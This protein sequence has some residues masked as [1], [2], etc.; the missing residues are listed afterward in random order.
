MEEALEGYRSFPGGNHPATVTR[1]KGQLRA[2]KQRDGLVFWRIAAAIALLLVS[3]TVVWYVNSSADKGLAENAAEPER[4]QS[5]EIASNF[6]KRDTIEL[7]EV[8]VVAED[9]TPSLNSYTDSKERIRSI[10]KEKKEI[11]PSP[12]VEA[13]EARQPPE[14]AKKEKVIQAPENLADQEDILADT[15]KDVEGDPFKIFD[16]MDME[17]EESITIGEE[18]AAVEDSV[19]YP[20]EGR[21]QFLSGRVT[22]RFGDPV[23]G[24]IIFSPSLERRVLTDDLGKI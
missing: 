21:I 5:T 16:E 3:G 6:I 2:K 20:K 10:A 13:K 7:N 12:I 1:L 19:G 17:V 14:P 11:A 8:E 22:N 9:I 24:A 15:E 18:I 23:I 4:E